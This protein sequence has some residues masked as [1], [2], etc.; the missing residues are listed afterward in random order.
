MSTIL[1]AI[2]LAPFALL[3]TAALGSLGGIIGGAAG[4]LAGIGSL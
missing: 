3:E 1:T 4:S 2:L